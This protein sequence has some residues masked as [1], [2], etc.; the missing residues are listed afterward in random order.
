[1]KVDVLTTTFPDPNKLLDDSMLTHL[2]EGK[3]FSLDSFNQVEE[4]DEKGFKK[5]FLWDSSS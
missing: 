3:T 5:I 1:M 2:L 4:E